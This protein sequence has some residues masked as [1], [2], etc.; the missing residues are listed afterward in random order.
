LRVV[1]A[2]R[3]ARGVE[4]GYAHAEGAHVAVVK[5]PTDDVAVVVQAH[6]FCK[7]PSVRRIDGAI[8]IDRA[9]LLGED[10][11][12]EVPR[13]APIEIGRASDCAVAI[14]AQCVADTAAVES[15]EIHHAARRDRQTVRLR[16]RIVTG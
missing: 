9:K 11:G 6:G 1:L 7:H 13:P 16:D 10:G 4:A 14:D 8:E 5:A 2:T 15:P 3:N 12:S